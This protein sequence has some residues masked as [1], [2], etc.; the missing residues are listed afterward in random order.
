[1]SRTE[2]MLATLAHLAAAR[3]GSDGQIL[4][5][6][7]HAV[8]LASALNLAPADADDLAAEPACTDAEQEIHDRAA[9]LIERA[10]T[11]HG[12]DER[13]DQHR[14]RTGHFRRFGCC[15]PA[16]QHVAERRFAVGDT[17][18]LRITQ[19]GTWTDQDL[20]DEEDEDNAR[21]RVTVRAGDVGRVTVVRSY[22]TP[23]PYAV[24]FGD[25]E[26]GVPEE[27]LERVATAW[28]PTEGDVV[29]RP[30]TDETWVVR[31][32]EDDD[33]VWVHRPDVRMVPMIGRNTAT[34]VDLVGWRDEPEHEELVAIADLSPAEQPAAVT[35]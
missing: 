34:M 29:T 5:H 6:A 4:R 19:S 33:F 9:A 24:M 25:Q 13:A 3:T 35:R 7:L 28:A 21:V 15:A 12:Q 16:V 30:G 14:S 1:M 11:A 2:R 17:V 20:A 31:S 23:F 26:I 22:P 8:L 18:R 27:A 10:R 32:Y